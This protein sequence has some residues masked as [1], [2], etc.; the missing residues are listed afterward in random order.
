MEDR[1]LA[2]CELSNDLLFHKISP[3]GWDT[4]WME[5]W[6]QDAGLPGIFRGDPYS[7]SIRKTGSPSAMPA[8]ASR[9]MASY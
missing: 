5:R 6:T 4:M 3:T 2:L 8:A 9:A 7:R 1:V